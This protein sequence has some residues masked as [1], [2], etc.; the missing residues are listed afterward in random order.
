MEPVRKQVIK[1][2]HIF[3]DFDRCEIDKLCRN[4]DKAQQEKCDEEFTER[5]NH[6]QPYPFTL[7]TND[8]F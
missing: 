1:L 4:C 3:R 7:K 2:I 5:E 6:P 8:P